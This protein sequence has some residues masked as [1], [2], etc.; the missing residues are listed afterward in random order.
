MFAVLALLLVITQLG[1]IVGS[2]GGWNLKAY[3]W[4]TQIW[5][6]L[7]RLEKPIALLVL[8]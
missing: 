5:L 2:Q 7:S 8:Y 3:K 6:Q 4:D 1:D